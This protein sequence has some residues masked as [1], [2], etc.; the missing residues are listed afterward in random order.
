[1]PRPTNDEFAPF[2]KNYIDKVQGDDLY[3]ALSENSKSTLAFWQSIKEEFADNTYAPGKWS[4][5][6]LLNHVIDSERIFAYRAL[7]IA[8]GDKTP[9]PGFNENDYADAAQVSHRSLK[10]MVH[11]FQAVRSATLSLF[12]SFGQQ[13]LSRKGTA[14]GNSVSVNAIGFTIIGHCIHHQN[15]LLEM[16]NLPL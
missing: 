5:K 13:E 7:C 11:E 16:Y 12:N 15:V 9:L 6:Q 2:Y 4:V 14:N 8:R 1:M 10:E 3:L